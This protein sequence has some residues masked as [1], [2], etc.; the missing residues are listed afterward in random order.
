[1]PEDVNPAA[2]EIK[3]GEGALNRARQ[4]A[5]EI[6]RQA[7]VNEGNEY[8]QQAIDDG[9]VELEPRDKQKASGFWTTLSSEE[10]EGVIDWVQARKVDSG[11]I[12]RSLVVAPEGQTSS[13]VFL[14]GYEMVGKNVIRKL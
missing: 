3:I 8:A 7:D 14:P 10:R 6:Q 11:L 13:M 4:V 5:D 9:E 1:M 2:E 12:V